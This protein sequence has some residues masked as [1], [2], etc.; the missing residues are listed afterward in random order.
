MTQQ[1]TDRILA[2]EQSYMAM[3][4]HRNFRKKGF[5]PQLTEK[6]FWQRF[7]WSYSIFKGKLYF[8]SIGGVQ[9]FL[10]V[11]GGGGSNR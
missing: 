11:G 5:R 3:R 2:N 9:H 4:G 6:K 1:E 8:D 10:G 7:S